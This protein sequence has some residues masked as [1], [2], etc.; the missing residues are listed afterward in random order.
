MKN[1]N[2]D[3]ARLLRVENPS[4][5]EK[6]RL[7][8]L[9]F[10]A[11][12]ALGLFVHPASAQQNAQE[13]LTNAS[14]VKLVRAGF[15][16]KTIVAIIRSRPGRFDLA[17]DRLIELKRSGVSENIILTMIGQD[18]SEFMSD[19]YGFESSRSE[20]LGPSAR[21]GSQRDQGTDIFGSSGGSKS[22][23]TGRG[24]SG[25]N[26]GNSV[27]T[28]SAT[29]HIV[30]PPTEAGGIPRLEKTP[31]LTNEAIIE[32]VDA[33]FSEGT[34][35]RRIEHS[36]ADFNLSPTQVT[37]LHKHRVSAPVIAAMRAAMGDDPIPAK[38]PAANNPEK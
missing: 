24:E 36:P 37:E 4:R 32:M 17:P 6:L 26:E 34:I 7:A 1:M 5:S 31:T 19:E 22:Q 11:C 28:G 30:R 15:R 8:S 33:G 9:A 2:L 29:V 18:D 14:V 21:R 12:L 35:I 3:S 10:L 13:P 23:T 20:G 25:G 27:T 38:P 16:E